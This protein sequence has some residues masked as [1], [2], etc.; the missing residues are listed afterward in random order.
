[1]IY[2]HRHF[3]SLAMWTVLAC[4]NCGAVYAEPLDLD[5]ISKKQGPN[6]A[7]ALVLEQ[8]GKYDEAEQYYSKSIAEHPEHMSSY[9][10]RA[11]SL[12]AMRK[13]KDAL[14]D[15]NRYSQL[16]DQTSNR[17]DR[18][19]LSG[20]ELMKAN[21]LQGLGQTND[22]VNCYK[23]A[24]S[25]HESV[26]GHVDLASLYADSNQRDLALQEIKKAENM[27]QFY[28]DNHTD[29]TLYLEK[30]KLSEVLKKL[31]EQPEKKHKKK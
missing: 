14:N 19:W 29:D 8:Q 24:L 28:K 7:R 30:Q 20:P 27:I 23:K 2:Q 3:F 26:K 21:A 18:N 13:F 25:Y 6:Y 11:R 16:L 12:I 22:A 5:V 31:A 15:V 1:M 17:G 4:L 9:M 10:G